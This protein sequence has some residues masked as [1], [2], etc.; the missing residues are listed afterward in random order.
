[1]NLKKLFVRTKTDFSNLEVSVYFRLEERTKR[2]VCQQLKIYNPR[3]IKIFEEVNRMFTEK[4]RFVKGIEA[5]QC[6]LAPIIGPSNCIRAFIPRDAGVIDLPRYFEGFPI[7][8]IYE[9]AT[10]NYRFMIDRE[11]YKTQSSV[12]KATAA[13]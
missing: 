3:H 4:Y 1:M 11:K 9:K 10:P 13:S 8:R 5:S 2:M 7:I 6:G 12:E